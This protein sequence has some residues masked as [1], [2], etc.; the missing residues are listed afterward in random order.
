MSFCVT[1][2]S[3]CCLVFIHPKTFSLSWLSND[4]S[5]QRDD[6]SVL[7][8]G[9]TGTDNCSL[10]LWPRYQTTPH[11]GTPKHCSP[12]LGPRHRA[13][14]G[15]CTGL[16]WLCCPGHR[17]AAP[18]TVN[19]LGHP[20]HTSSIFPLGEICRAPQAPALSLLP[21]AHTPIVRMAEMCNEGWTTATA[22]CGDPLFVPH[23]A[24][25]TDTVTTHSNQTLK[26]DDFHMVRTDFQIS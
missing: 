25:Q 24:Q 3:L 22:S 9:M 21:G 10:G 11:A 26:I 23:Q 1:L 12:S 13:R 2:T 14:P 6:L 5:W 18:G 4:C 7:A 16:C 15:S 17:G 8:G 19:P 20:G